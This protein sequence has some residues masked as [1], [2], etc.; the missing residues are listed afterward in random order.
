MMSLASS[1]LIALNR[2]GRDK[3]EVSRCCSIAFVVIEPPASVA[4]TMLENTHFSGSDNLLMP[5]SCSIT[6]INSLSRVN[7]VHSKLDATPPSPYLY[8]NVTV[9]GGRQRRRD[10]NPRDLL[11]L[12]LLR[13]IPSF[14][15]ENSNLQ[16]QRLIPLK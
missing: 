12:I 6:N 3:F 4:C 10:S 8:R 1:C 5:R 9:R 2:V 15:I 16:N 14:H 7:V 13:L 11:S